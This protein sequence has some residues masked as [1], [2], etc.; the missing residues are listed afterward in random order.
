MNNKEYGKRLLAQGEEISN[1]TRITGLN[2]NDL[3]VGTS[4]TGKTGGYVIPTIQNNIGSLVVSDTKGQLEQ[5]F[6][7]ELEAKGYKVR[8]IDFVNPRRSCGYNPL[9]FI[10]RYEDGSLREQDILTV[11][12]LICPDLQDNEPIWNL[13]SAG[14]VAFLIGF[15]MEA[16]DE[17]KHNL[18]TIVELR[19]AFSKPNGDLGFLKWINENPDTFAAKKYHELISNRGADKMWASVE[20]FVNSHLEV[21]DC[22]EM[23][24]IFASDNNFDLNDLGHEKTVLF[25][26]QSDTD[27]AFDKVVNLL[28][29]QILHTLCT[30]ADANKDKVLDI[31]VRV[32]LDDFASGSKIPDFDKVISVIRSRDISVSLIIQ[33]MTQLESMYDHAT[34]LTIVNN[35]D[36]ILYLGSQDKETAEYIAFRACRTPESVLSMPR[37]MAY[38]IRSGEKAKLVRKTVP[39]STCNKDIQAEV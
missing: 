1:N 33:S 14:Y 27:R 22:K 12:K 18:K 8:V 16:C 37:D 15:C 19:R 28:N 11:A 2:N 9:A 38:L 25:I 34:S 17:S 13:C 23:D 4:G 3:I 5:K 20:G 6:R 21:F 26:N 31:P 35:C 24:N 10:R 36:H 32:I 29:T 30:Q 39:Y 7:N